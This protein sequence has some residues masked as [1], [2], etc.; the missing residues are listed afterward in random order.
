M[1]KPIADIRK[2]YQLGE[3]KASQMPDDPIIAFEKW[4]QEAIESE[5]EEPTAFQLSTISESGYPHSRIVLLKGIENE[6]FVFFTNYLSSKGKDINFN[7]QVAMNF[8]WPEL[9]RQVRIL[10]TAKRIDPTKS[11]AYFYSRPLSSQAGA[12]VSAQSDVIPEELDLQTEIDKLLASPEKIQRPKHWGGYSINPIY[13]EFWQG[14]PSRIHDRVF[15]QKETSIKWKKG[16]L[17]P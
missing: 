10:G 9:E 14:R 1:K 12:V 3:I 15:Y 13:I 17:A 7:P 11:D 4:L 16:R 2:D 5:V 6:Q 8:F